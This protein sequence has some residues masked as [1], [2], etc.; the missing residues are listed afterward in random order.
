M[1]LT[2]R[3]TRVSVA[4][5]IVSTIFFPLCAHADIRGDDIRSIKTLTERMLETAKTG[6]SAA[7]ESSTSGATGRVR[8]ISTDHE[9]GRQPCRRYEWSIETVSGEELITRGE[10]CRATGGLWT[11]SER[12]T[13]RGS[14][15]AEPEAPLPARPAPTTREEPPDRTD[16]PA[17]VLKT[18]AA[19]PAPVEEPKDPL[20]D[21]TFTRPPRSSLSPA[22]T[23]ATE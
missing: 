4:A 13:R 17:A 2:R 3:M 9:T 16:L 10:G 1:I 19:S 6:T 8:I 23:H 7:W 15:R 18:E 20:A 14:P 12:S 21:L 22:P 11:L 5:M